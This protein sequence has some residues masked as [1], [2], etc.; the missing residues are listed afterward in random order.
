VDESE[1]PLSIS[2]H[3][4]RI[5]DGGWWP[6]FRDVVSPHG[7]QHGIGYRAVLRVTVATVHNVVF[8]WALLS[9]RKECL[10][11]RGRS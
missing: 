4:A 7:H 6:Q 9:C 11:P 10:I 3:H 1:V 8:H 5:S 2:L